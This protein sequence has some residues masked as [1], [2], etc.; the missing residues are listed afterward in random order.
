MFWRDTHYIGNYLSGTIP[1][2]HTG[3]I[4]MFTYSDE[5]I[6]DHSVFC[7]PTGGSRN[8]SFVVRPVQDPKKSQFPNNQKK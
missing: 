1:L 5:K 3:N 8:F 2:D 4:F 7:S 6:N